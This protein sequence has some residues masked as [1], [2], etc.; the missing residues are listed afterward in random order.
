[1]KGQ[2]FYKQKAKELLGEHAEIH[3][4]GTKAKQWIIKAET[5]LIFAEIHRICNQH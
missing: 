1:M 2:D 5:L 4:P 3:S